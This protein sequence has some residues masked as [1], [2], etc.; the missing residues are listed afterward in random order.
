[1][2]R[3]G[4]HLKRKFRM[5]RDA[6][7][8]GASACSVD[9]ILTISVPKRPKAAPRVLTINAARAAAGDVSDEVEHKAEAEAS[10][11]GEE[12]MPDATE[13]DAFPA[14]AESAAPAPA[15][16]EDSVMV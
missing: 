8:P 2:K 10:T 7:T 5:P 6:D 14:P 1:M 12:A 9:G 15:D 13:A 16:D 3:T 11:A 4:A